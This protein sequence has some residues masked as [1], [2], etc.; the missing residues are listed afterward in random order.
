[1]D[2][3]AFLFYFCAQNAA[4][5]LDEFF[6]FGCFMEASMIDRRLGEKPVH[7]EISMG[8][9]CI[10]SPLL[11]IHSKLCKRKI[12]LLNSYHFLSECIYMYF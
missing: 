1:M 9:N 12:Y 8:K 4:G 2:D 3:N 6:L 7:F 10:N 5:K 11:W